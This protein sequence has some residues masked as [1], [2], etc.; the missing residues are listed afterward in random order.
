MWAG[1]RGTETVTEEETGDG[2][3]VQ[4]YCTVPA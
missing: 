1:G 3:S 4:V 2:P